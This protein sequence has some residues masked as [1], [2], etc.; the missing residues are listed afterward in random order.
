M[1]TL[2]IAVCTVFLHL[3]ADPQP[4]VQWL[5]DTTYDFGTMEQGVPRSV[6]FSFKNRSNQTIVL[7]TTRTTCGCTAAEWTE[8]PIEPGQTGAVTIEYDAYRKGR[9]KKKITVFFDRQKKPEVLWI[10]GIVE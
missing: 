1:T 3:S 6:S 8:T 10:S 4:I 9:F 2:L 7:E 5:N